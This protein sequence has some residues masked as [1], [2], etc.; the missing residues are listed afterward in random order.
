MKVIFFLILSLL[1][2]DL[3]AGG[4]QK[5]YL[6]AMLNIDKNIVV[7]PIISL[8]DGKVLKTTKSIYCDGEISCTV[9]VK[10]T[11]SALG[12]GPDMNTWFDME[13]VSRVTRSGYH[14]SNPLGGAGDTLDG[15][16]IGSQKHNR[17]LERSVMYVGPITSVPGLIASKTVR[18]IEESDESEVERILASWR[19]KYF[20]ECGRFCTNGVNKLAHFQNLKLKV[21]EYQLPGGR[22]FQHFMGRSTGT[23]KRETT[24]EVEGDT[25]YVI[26]D[27]WKYSDAKEYVDQ[28]RVESVACETQC[29]GAWSGSPDVIEFR[30]TLYILGELYGGTQYGYCLFKVKDNGLELLAS[31]TGGS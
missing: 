2:Q 24:E 19:K 10:M 14:N 16:V 4:D 31:L 23:V 11:L 8:P 12:M 3:M 28:S 21:T 20:K 30:N 9:P 26:V 13:G 15:F 27:F 29:G 7:W 17:E 22:K 5:V 25:L 6:G 1:S 18:N